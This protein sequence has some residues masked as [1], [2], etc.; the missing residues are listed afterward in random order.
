MAGI[1][2]GHFYYGERFCIIFKTIDQ[3]DRNQ[4]ITLCNQ[5]IMLVTS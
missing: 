4:L 2:T 5:Y 1:I 3:T